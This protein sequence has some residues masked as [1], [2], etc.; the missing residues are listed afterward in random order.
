[1][2]QKFDLLVAGEINPDLILTGD[3]APVF[4]QTEKLAKD[5]TLTIGSSSVICACGAARLGLKVAFTGICGDDLFGEFMLEAM[6]SRSVNVDAVRVDPGEKTGLSVILNRESDRAI[7]TYPGLIGALTGR[8]IPNSLLESARHLHVGSLFLQTGLRPDLPGLF[9]R[10]HALGL[11]ISLDANWDPAGKWEGFE[12]LLKNVDIFFANEVEIMAISNEKTLEK[13]AASL[14]LQ[15]LMVVIKRG[16]DGAMAQCGREVFQAPALSVE[17]VDTVG[18]GDSF[19]AGFLY[20]WLQSWNLEKS[21]RMASICG[22]LSTRAAGGTDLQ[23]T[24]E[25]ALQFMH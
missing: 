25:E 20:G 10:A 18:A 15:C 5:A 12:T 9:D 24:L 8:D 17:V 6:T 1:M 21:L 2:T 13:A 22:S 3:I 14:A 16:A 7:L 23:P 11:T 4:G 19:D